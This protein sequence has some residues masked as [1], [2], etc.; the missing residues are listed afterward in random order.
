MYDAA[1]TVRRI[2][3]IAQTD[4][5]LAQHGAPR[6]RIEALARLGIAPSHIGCQSDVFACGGFYDSNPRTVVQDGATKGR[7]VARWATLAPA[8]PDAP[9]PFD[10]EATVRWGSTTGPA[11]V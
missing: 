6:A 7:L 10:L 1:V 3:G 2:D 4:V 5:M 8:G 9:F 11:S